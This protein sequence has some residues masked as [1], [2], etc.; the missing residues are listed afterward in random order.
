[1][2]QIPFISKTAKEFKRRFI[3]H[4]LTTF[5]IFDMR[6]DMLALLNSAADITQCRPATGKLRQIQL[7]DLELL[8]LFD[9]LCKKHGLTYF[10]DWGTLLGTVRHK[11]F[12]PWD[13]DLDVC[14]PREDYIRAVPIIIDFFKDREGFYTATQQDADHNWMWVNYWSA[15]VLIDIFPL[16]SVKVPD[17]FTAEEI[18]GAVESLRDG[19]SAS[20]IPA[21]D[22]EIFYYGRLLWQGKEYYPREM[23]FPLKTLPFEGYELPVPNDS[24]SILK[25]LYGD[26][27]AF[28]KSG[29]CHHKS[30]IDN[31]SYTDEI[32]TKAVNEIRALREELNKS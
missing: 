4:T 24:D 30:L 19:G 9:A 18:T 11:G 21:G 15:A 29:V 32:L 17:S 1:M 6:D 22:R 10:L 16:D 8:R 31:P 2:K 5:G 12:I 23:I 13:D 3:K 27:M 14:M 28:P 26:Y 7:G 20:D 25:I